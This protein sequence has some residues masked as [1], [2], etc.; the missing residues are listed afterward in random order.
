MATATW[1]GRAAGIDRIESLE[2]AS[3]SSAVAALYERNAGRLFGYCLS[4]LGRREDAEDAVQTTFLH[5]IRG[6]RRGVVPLVE[7]AWLLG[8]ARNVC[9]TRRE[10]LGR[11]KK[12]ESV[13]D[14][15]DLE[16]AAAASPAA[17]DELVG[18]Q[19]AL[20]E[21]PDRQRRAVLLR[22]WRGLSYE[23][24]AAELEVSHAAVETLIFRGRQTLAAL[25][26][27]ES[28]K[29]RKRLASLG[30]LGSFFAAVKTA[31]TG[32]AAAVKVAVAVVAVSTAGL[33]A[34]TLESATGTAAPPAASGAAAAGVAPGAAG[35][36][37]SGRAAGRTRA[38]SAPPSSGPPAEPRSGLARQNAAGSPSRR[39]GGAQGTA[40]GAVA[41]LAGTPTE[42][43]A[44]PAGAG[45]GQAAAAAPAA[46]GR[47]AAPVASV[48]T[49]V[50]KVVE[51]AASVA[52]RS[53]PPVLQ[54]PVPQVPPVVKVPPLPGA[55]PSLP[56]APPVPVP[57]PAAPAVP[58]PPVAVTP[59]PVVP[60]P[61]APPPVAPAPPSLPVPPVPTPPVSPP[62]VPA[63]P[64]SPPP[65]P[66]VVP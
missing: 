49:K 4:R 34:G 39:R 60:P 55:P 7:S 52:A 5:A 38:A 17:R 13:C 43:G 10:A 33:A 15:H 6:L 16:N 22:D 59:P 58:A 12:L 25:L 53:E 62:T 44:A 28:R 9:L 35:P 64:V 51:A 31:V 11:R 40:T 8:I 30:N 27:E 19:G 63:P 61:V 32:G 41:V 14:P 50:G 36:G 54:T 47:A 29:T 2:A 23:E 66:P 18:L 42:G 26:G 48:A 56:V 24:I 57:V 20:A 1:R 21:L 37:V 45:L 65:V 3:D 46:A